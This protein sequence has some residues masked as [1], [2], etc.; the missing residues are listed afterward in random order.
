MEIK[1][2]YKGTTLITNVYK[3]STKIWPMGPQEF[4]FTLFLNYQYIGTGSYL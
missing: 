3:R 2:L 4:N 1:S